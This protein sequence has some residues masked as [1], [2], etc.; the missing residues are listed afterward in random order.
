MAEPEQLHSDRQLAGPN[1]APARLGRNLT[2]GRE[3]IA[4][5]V[6]FDSPERL[7]T[8]LERSSL[9]NVRRHETP[10]PDEPELRV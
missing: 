1:P 4:A 7:Q 2:K 8:L 10:P 5:I 9:A 6:G 3:N